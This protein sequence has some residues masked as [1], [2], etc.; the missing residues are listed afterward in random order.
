MNE[1]EVKPTPTRGYVVFQFS[2]L[3]IETRP[4][5]KSVRSKRV[6]LVGRSITSSVTLSVISSSALCARI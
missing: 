4:A 3:E 2:I 6:K 1:G 5:R